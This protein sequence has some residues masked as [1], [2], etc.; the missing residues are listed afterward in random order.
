VGL[1]L[2]ANP[3]G[4]ILVTAGPIVLGSAIRPVAEKPQDVPAAKGDDRATHQ[5][6]IDAG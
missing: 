5:L 2:D 1:V 4:T 6:R 3:F